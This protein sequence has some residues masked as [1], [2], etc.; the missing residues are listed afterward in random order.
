[1]PS[2]SIAWTELSRSAAGNTAMAV[3]A[4]QALPD[5]LNQAVTPSSP[6][7]SRSAVPDPSMSASRIRRGSNRS[8]LSKRG[9]RSMVTLAPNRP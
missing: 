3:G 7:Y 1:M 8:S 5:W 2:R 9:A 4:D 6:M